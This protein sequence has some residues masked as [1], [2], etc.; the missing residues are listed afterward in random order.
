MINRLLNNYKFTITLSIAL[1]FSLIIGFFYGEDLNFGATMDWH[2]TNYPVIRDSAVDLKNTLL[3]YESY[4][5]RHSPLYPIFLGQFLK[6]G[7]SYEFI[8][9]IHLNISIL[10]IYVF[11]K[12]LILVFPVL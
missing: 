12:C 11:Y 2:G 8:R 9:F 10:L 1:Y 5:H 3:N 7:L 4:G 6:L